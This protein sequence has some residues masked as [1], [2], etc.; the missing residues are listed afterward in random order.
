[1]RRE[2]PQLWLLTGANGSGK[3]TY[4]ESFL[5]PTGLKLVNADSIA[6]ILDPENPEALSYD[7]AVLAENILQ[8]LLR[9][10]I[11]FCYETVFSHRSKIEL[12]AGAKALGYH[13][14]LLYIHLETPELNE[15]RVFQRISEGGHSVPIDKIHTRIPRTMRNVAE[16]M[17]LVNE[18]RILDNSLA[19]HPFRELAVVKNGTPNLRTKSTP[20]WV[21]EILKAVL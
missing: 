5:A 15:A 19:Q 3:S 1:M 10:G 11:S 18:A 9:N 6:R 8:L 14:L 7:A 2:P 12:V 21:R 16:V 13:I 4:Y 20:G 17:P